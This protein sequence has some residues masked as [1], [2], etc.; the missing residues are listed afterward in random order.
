MLTHKYKQLCHQIEY[1][2]LVICVSLVI[3]YV[4]KC[5]PLPR[6]GDRIVAIKVLNHGN[7]Y[8]ERTALEGR[9]AR[10]VTMMSRV[11]HENLVKVSR[12]MTVNLALNC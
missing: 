2:V 7:N 1:F 12:L 9:F 8:E 6:Y 4:D 3:C 5:N 10:E 11:K